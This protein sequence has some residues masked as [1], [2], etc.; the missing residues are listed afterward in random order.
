VNA[1]TSVLVQPTLGDLP[2]PPPKQ[3]TRAERDEQ[4]R[5]ERDARI[6]AVGKARRAWLDQALEQ[7]ALSRAELIDQLRIG[8]EVEGYGKVGHQFGRQSDLW[9]LVDERIAAW[10]QR[11]GEEAYRPTNAAT[12][13]KRSRLLADAQAA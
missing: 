13:K 1:Q 4:W 12:H 6:E 7:R 2:A 11:T 5:A 3:P 8:I 9:K 10:R